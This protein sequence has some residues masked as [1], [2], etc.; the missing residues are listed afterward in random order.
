MMNSYNRLAIIL[1][2]CGM[3]ILSQAQ[4]FSY[5]L[6][7]PQPVYSD[8]VGYGYDIVAPPTAK[9][10]SPFYFSVKVPDGNYKVTVTLGAKKK[11]AHTV[12]RAE[13]RRLFVEGAKTR[14]GEFKTC[15]FIVSK[16]SPYINEK[17]NVRIK[18]REKDYLNWDNRLTLEFNGTAPA[19]KQIKIERDTTAVTLF[20][21]GNSTVVDQDLEPWA[22]WGQMIPRWFTDKV[23]ISNHAESGLTASSFLAQNRLEKILTMMRP[24]DYVFCEFGHNDQ[25][26][27]GPGAGA[28]YNF[29]FALKKFIDIVRAKQ[30]NVVF[31]TPT[32]RRQFDDAKTHIKETHANYPE[33]MRA[34][35]QREQVP[36]IE[37]HDMTRTFFETLGFENSKRGLVHYPANTFPN[38][39]KEL[40]DNTHFN[41]YGAYEVAKMVVMGMKELKLPFV[42]Y[43]VPEWVD[44]N[45]AAPDDFNL[46][47]WYPSVIFETKKPDGN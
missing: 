19:V 31:I 37:L 9:S 25:K 26:E 27:K 46:F 7:A 38:Q 17:M 30:G 15:S 10:T 20:L 5:D 40:A 39:T 22:S 11:A 35:A 8:E 21:C 14:K 28:Y 4:E 33:A 6:T 34:V 2:F 42:G 36:V 24:G 32:Q 16:R 3:G 45:P 29:A 12:V 44:Y 41:P 18:E 13:S 43:L 47:E 23:A 1:A